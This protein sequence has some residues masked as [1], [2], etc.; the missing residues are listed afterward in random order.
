MN[1]DIYA[2]FAK[3]LAS[4]PAIIEQFQIGLTW[5]TCRVN[6]NGHQSLGFAMTPHSQTRLLD[7]PGTIA[8]QPVKSLLGYLDSSNEFE[9]AL[10]ISAINAIVNSESNPLPKDACLVKPYDCANVSLFNHFKPFLKHKKVVVIGRYPHLESVM[11]GIDYQVI[12]RMP[13]KGDLPD[14]AA[15]YVLPNADWV[16][17][18]ASSLVNKTFPRLAELAR[19]AVTVLMGPSMPWL[20][21]FVDNGV[22]FLAGV[23]V[24]D[25]AKAQQIAMEGG[26]IR[27]FGTGVEYAVLN[28][29]QDR[30]HT[31]KSKIA[32]TVEHRNSLKQ[33]MEACYAAGNSQRFSKWRILEEVDQKLSLLDTAYKR[34]WDVNEA[35]QSSA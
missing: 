16:F 1:Q 14:S 19:N 26:G 21:D 20:N 31:L 11:Q 12:E 22:D 27:L 34:L 24:K 25:I 15:E 13:Q 7:W 4:S 18:T 8:G 35:M 17:I 30:M 3:H 29:S 5:T 6:I 10:V 9:M 28:I 32:E 33:E 23:T 2:I